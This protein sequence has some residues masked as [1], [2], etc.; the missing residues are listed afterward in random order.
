MSFD[1]WS[2]WGR[3]NLQA[4]QDG[5][6][7]VHQSHNDGSLLHGFLCVF[8]L[9]YPALR[10]AN[11]PRVRIWLFLAESGE[12]LQGDGIVVVVVPEHGGGGNE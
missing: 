9:E 8:N 5:M 6:C 12:I 2:C 11:G 4:D 3:A 1:L 7:L 10:G